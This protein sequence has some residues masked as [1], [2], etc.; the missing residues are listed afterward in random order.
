[1]DGGNEQRV[2]KK[3]YFKPGLSAIDTLVLVQKAYRNEGMNR[4]TVFKWY[5]RFRDGR[6]LVEDERCGHPKPTRTAINIAAV[7][8]LVKNDSR[9]AS[10]MIAESLNIP[11]AVVLRI[12]KED[13][14]KRELCARFVPHSLAPGE[15]E[16]RATSCQ[17][18][19]AMAD[20]D[21]IF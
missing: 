16:D 21:N 13:L 20:A 2:A 11:K 18:I 1:M 19:I 12:L 15:R 8:D 6:E 9:I 17:D 3:N 10:R 4:S 7:A 14:G 5:S